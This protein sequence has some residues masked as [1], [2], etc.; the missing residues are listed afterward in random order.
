MEASYTIL[1]MNISTQ[2]QGQGK[3][4]KLRV[5]VRVGESRLGLMSRLGLK[6]QG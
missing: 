4:A 6:G 2:G 1:Y 3:R 5:K